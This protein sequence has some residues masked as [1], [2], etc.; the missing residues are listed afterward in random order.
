MGEWRPDALDRRHLCIAV[1]DP[2]A[3]AL[4]RDPWSRRGTKVVIAVGL[5]MIGLLRARWRST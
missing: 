3:V 5:S 1:R 4:H 2:F